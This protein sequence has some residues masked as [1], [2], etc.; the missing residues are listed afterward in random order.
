MRDGEWKKG[1]KHRANCPDRSCYTG[2]VL[3]ERY[4]QGWLGEGWSYLFA[5]CAAVSVGQCLRC[6]PVS[7]KFATLEGEPIY[8]FLVSQ[9]EL[10]WHAEWLQQANEAAF[11]P[12]IAKFLTMRRRY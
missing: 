1:E 11:E 3:R 10:V 7:E 4:L 2:L 5:E 8:L 9:G 6:Y 12:A